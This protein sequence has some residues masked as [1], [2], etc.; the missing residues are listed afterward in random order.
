M[1]IGRKSVVLI[2]DVEKDERVQGNAKFLLLIVVVVAIEN[3]LCDPSTQRN[4]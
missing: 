1:A 3:Q 2:S 4:T